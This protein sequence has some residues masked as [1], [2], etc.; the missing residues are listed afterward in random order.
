[1]ATKKIK[2]EV[3]EMDVLKEI[4]EGV[5]LI[6]KQVVDINDRLSAM[7]EHIEMIK[8]N[9]D[10]IDENIHELDEIA[11]NITCAECDEDKETCED[12]EEH[13]SV[14]GKMLK[15][16]EDEECNDDESSDYEKALND[17]MEGITNILKEH[18]F[19]VDGGC[20][21]DPHRGV[22]CVRTKAQTEPDKDEDHCEAVYEFVSTVNGKN[23]RVRTNS[24]DAL[25]EHLQ[26]MKK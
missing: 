9:T 15:D 23:R 22:S 4:A 13:S 2:T 14:H 8:I 21:I 26:S 24:L 12:D 25:I 10:R 20:I 11:S 6:A 16:D 19:A 1:M 17:A 3:T 7:E 18:G 5:G